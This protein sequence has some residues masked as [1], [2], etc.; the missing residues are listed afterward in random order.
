[1]SDSFNPD[2]LRPLFEP[3]EPPTKHRLPNPVEDGPAIVEAGRRPSKCLLVPR[4][5]H[6]VDMW[7][8][9]GYVGASDT[10]KTL[11]CHWFDTAHP[12]D[13]RYHWCQREAIET[14]IWL[15][16]VV[17]YR[18][19]S[20]MI[21]SL[22]EDEAGLL[23]DSVLPEEDI[24]ARYCCK[25]ATGGGKTKVMSLAIVWSYFHSLFEPCS[26]LARHF[27][28]IAPNLIVF[29]RLKEDFESGNIFFTDPLLPPEWRDDFDLEVVLQDAPGGSSRR[30]ALYL[31]NIHR[32]YEKEGASRPDDSPPWAGP[33]V[34][35]AQALRVGEELRKRIAAHPT[36][37]VLNDEAHHLHDPESA[38][39]EA[40]LTLHR[41]SRD[42]GNAGICAQLD[43][44]ATP[45]HNDGTLFRHIV[46]DFPLGEA[47]DA[48]I[49]KAPVIG[50]SD[51]IKEG[52]GHSA[53]Q[54]YH[55][56]LKLGYA[57][58]EKAYKE[59]E[60]THKPILFVMTED[61][62]AADEIATALNSDE[63]PLLKNRVINL[64]TNLKGT[65]RTRGRGRNA[66]REFVPNEKQIS[67]ED[68]RLLR[69]LSRDLDKEDS[70]Y[71]CVVSVMM[72]REG[73]D[74]RNVTTIVPLRPYSA[75]SNILA[76]QTLG[77]GLRRMTAPGSGGPLERVT[78]V[79]HPAFTKL[80]RDELAS[81]GLFPAVVEFG[82]DRPSTVSIYVDPK[83]PVQELE[84]EIPLLSASVTTTATLAGLT[85][86]DVEQFFRSKFKP[87]P[88]DKPSS[89]TVTFEERAL[90]TDE[91]V[92]SFEVDRGL[93]A[94]GATAVSVFVRDLERACRLQ[95]AHAVLAPLM[96][97]FIE[98]VLF[99]REVSL[100]DG[101]V[102]HRMGDTDVLEHIRATFIPLILQ[103]T[104]RQEERTRQHTRIPVSGWRP[105]QA[106]H[107]PERPCIP[108]A[109]TM[110]NLVPCTNSLE[111]QFADFCD[112]SDDVVAFARNAGPQKLTLDYLGKS[113]RPQLYWPDFIVRAKSG[114]YYL[115]ETKGQEDPS[116]PLKA[117]AAVEWCR[118]A[119]SKDQRW[120][121]LYVP[122]LLLEAQAEFSIE[123]LARTCA[124]RLKA[125][126]QTAKTT[127]A[128]LPLELTPDE[129][130]QE[131]VS[132]MAI[133]AGIAELPS[134]LSEY[135]SQAVNQLEYD[136]AKNY[137][138]YGAAFQPLLYPLEQ[139]C[140]E[141]LVRYL[142][143][144]VPQSPDEQRYYFDPH[145]E[146][147]PSPLVAALQ[148]NQRNLQRNLVHRAN[149][150]RIGTL[151]FCLEFGSRNDIRIAG[152]WDDVRRV[153]SDY[154]FDGLYAQL[155]AINKFRGKHV[156]H[157]DEPLTDPAVADN[158]MMDWIACIGRLWNL[159]RT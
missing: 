128:E 30:G 137:P 79:D 127:Q 10:T 83:K 146:G 133:A 32:L 26:T 45:K 129:V 156:A 134:A 135:V 73:W 13:F 96:Q 35:R 38:W 9:N 7:R 151:L 100:Y 74:V 159:A 60:K 21:E 116:V 22:L 114:D 29:E 66:V 14:I 12:G 68:L 101:S 61:T 49:V 64:H 55:T 86:E 85:K 136:R 63:Y 56:H 78:V 150:N 69:E 107:T 27:V 118:S 37:M 89:R 88:I 1:M 99:E 54:R 39:N 113:G 140:G 24:W 132:K 110:F 50:K 92:S 90:F 82:A 3:W 123:A 84:L 87:L 138:Q 20:G 65:I 16:E 106:S 4:L 36:I 91:L 53:G 17:Q 120:H 59:W 157:V 103:R 97:H 141:I 125:L 57:Q 52:I 71:R 5:R 33:S 77:R 67:D 115:V 111:A 121:Y 8:H 70:P 152:V 25:I 80:Y 95:S 130:K 98:K 41:Q 122:M 51:A 142:G 43:F 154:R 48:G 105:Y 126:L 2:A 42:R 145:V 58:Y 75:E 155:G 144:C 11:L 149:S 19:L 81:E 28:A 76:E 6:E 104:V 143:P 72:L 31:T 117:A 44:T 139:L 47:V 102:D 46:C 112:Q 34:K 93:L 108:A 124:P 153:F 119:S 131:R 148:K 109:K 62:R 40:I 94:M 147:L 18:S 158:A 15:Y 23:A